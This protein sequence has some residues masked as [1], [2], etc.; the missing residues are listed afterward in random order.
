[1]NGC[2][3]SWDG[4][5]G[6]TSRCRSYSSIST[7][8][9]RVNDLYGHAAGDDAIQSVAESIRQQLRE[10]DLGAR[11]GGDEFG[12]LAPRTSKEAAR[13]FGGAAARTR[14]EGDHACV[15]GATTMSIGIASLAAPSDAPLTATALLAAADEAL[16]WAKRDGGNRVADG[17]SDATTTT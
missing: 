12:V 5:L 2:A 6:F 8:L 1:M 4:W 14:G 16:Y 3:T 17:H 13:V 7:A 9:K 10:I 15:E 11:L